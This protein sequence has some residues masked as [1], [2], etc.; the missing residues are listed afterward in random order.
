MAPPCHPHP[1]H[2]CYAKGQR[3][4]PR[5]QNASR[6]RHDS[7]PLACDVDVGGGHYGG[8]QGQ[9]CRVPPLVPAP[10]VGRNHIVPVHCHWV[11]PGESSRRRRGIGGQPREGGDQEGWM[12]QR[13]AA[14]VSASSASDGW[15]TGRNLV[16]HPSGH[17]TD[18]LGAAHSRSSLALSVRNVGSPW[19]AQD[20]RSGGGRG[21]ALRRSLFLSPDGREGGMRSVRSLVAFRQ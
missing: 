15:K 1:C 9:Q 14:V 21:W 2:G 12:G 18:H 17:G 16:F 6:A 10:C 20:G 3:R 11:G 4:G 19:Q 5:R 8:R 13:D 7:A